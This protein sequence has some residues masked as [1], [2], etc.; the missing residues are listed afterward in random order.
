MHTMDFR[1]YLKPMSA[2]FLSLGHMTEIKLQ[3][4]SELRQATACKRFQAIRFDFR[5]FF[6]LREETWANGKIVISGFPIETISSISIRFWHCHHHDLPSENCSALK[7][8]FVLVE[9]PR[10][11]IIVITA[12]IT[13]TSDQYPYPSILSEPKYWENKRI[14]L[15]VRVWV[16]ERCAF[17]ILP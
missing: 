3:T 5:R 10:L 4:S 1:F 13:S 2:P 6:C 11:N 8:K 7:I 17:N 12:T 14:E 15:L 9:D 16:C